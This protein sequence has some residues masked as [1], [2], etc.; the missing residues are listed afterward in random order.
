MNQLIGFKHLILPQKQFYSFMQQI[1]ERLV[2]AGKLIEDGTITTFDSLFSHIPKTVIA[3]ALFGSTSKWYETKFQDP[4][5]FRVGELL[6]LSELMNIKA[7]SLLEIMK[8]TINSITDRKFSEK[9]KPLDEEVEKQ[10]IQAKE[11]KGKGMKNKDIYELMGISRMTLYR[12]LNEG[13]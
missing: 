3:L 4:Y 8:P 9:P 5:F 10:R 1:D 12:Y 13:D 6:K 2:K 7:N 11:L